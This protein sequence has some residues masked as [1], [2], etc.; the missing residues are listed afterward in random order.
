MQ[1]MPELRCFLSNKSKTVIE[2]A[3]EAFCALSN[4]TGKKSSMHEQFHHECNI[5]GMLLNYTGSLI[6]KS[7]FCKLFDIQFF[8]PFSAMCLHCFLIKNE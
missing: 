4:N 2:S 5:S 1:Q 6:L 7:N 8:V 3:L